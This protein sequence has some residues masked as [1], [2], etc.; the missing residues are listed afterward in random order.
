MLRHELPAPIDGTSGRSH[1]VPTSQPT[2]PQGTEKSSG[3]LRQVRLTGSIP[4]APT[5]R[6]LAAWPAR[7]EMRHAANAAKGHVA[8]CDAA[9]FPGGGGYA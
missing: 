1:S 9:R 7:P 3:M 8:W 2:G 5:I 6:A 4:V